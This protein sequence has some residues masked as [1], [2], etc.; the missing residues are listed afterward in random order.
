MS[1]QKSENAIDEKGL[2]VLFQGTH[3]EFFA[4]IGS[5]LSSKDCKEI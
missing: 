4:T 2:N 1:A 3:P 5:L